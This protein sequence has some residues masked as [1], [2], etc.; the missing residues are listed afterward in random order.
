MFFWSLRGKIVINRL[1]YGLSLHIIVRLQIFLDLDGILGST[2]H[3][4]VQLTCQVLA[5][6]NNI[7]ISQNCLN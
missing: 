3:T 6:G 5:R 7:H 4:L 1:S 2:F